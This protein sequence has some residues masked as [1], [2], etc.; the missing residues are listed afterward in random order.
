MRIWLNKYFDFTKREFNGLMILMFLIGLTMIFPYGYGLIFP[1]QSDEVA[2]QKAIQKLS[3]LTKE[4]PLVQEEDESAERGDKSAGKAFANDRKQIEKGTLFEFD[5]NLVSVKEWQRLGLS[6]K[7]GLVIIKYLSKGGHFNKAEDLKKM[8]TINPEMYARFSPYVRIGSKGADNKFDNTG[9][10]KYNKTAKWTDYK[11]WPDTKNGSSNGN[12]AER[13]NF[14]AGGKFFPTGNSKE[15]SA[16][17]LKIIE[18]NSAD[19]TQLEEI[20]GIGPAFARRIVKYR[21]RL[22]GFYRADQLM[23]VFGLDSVK[24]QEIK[25]QVRVDASYLKKINVNTAVLEDFKDHPYIRYKQVNAL[26]Q[27][28][29]QHGNYGNI[30]DVKK[31]AILTPEILTNLGPYLS[32]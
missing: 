21:N 18:L 28:R 27:Y 2:D 1:F 19:T 23:E 22:G 24:F 8:Y 26:I 5:P 13:A 9:N 20:K 31:V 15:Y 16:K 17:P 32:F 25:G 14:A 11:K 4:D 6:E 29:K 3:F 12:G 30:A 7:Q 10:T